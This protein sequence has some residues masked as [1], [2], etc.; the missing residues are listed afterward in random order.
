MPGY[1][2]HDTIGYVTAAVTSA[3]FGYSQLLT[4]PET[5]VY[6]AA[7]IIGTIWLSPDL[8]TDSKSYARW[9]IFRWYWYPYKKIVAHRSWL[10]HSGPLSATLRLIYLFFPLLVSTLFLPYSGVTPYEIE[11]LLLTWGKT[12]A[13]LWLGIIVADCVHTAADYITTGVKRGK[14]A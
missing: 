10:S 6:A 14:G 1:K 4:I 2:T 8:D 3:V 11:I 12:F 9:G 5:F 7:V 13:I